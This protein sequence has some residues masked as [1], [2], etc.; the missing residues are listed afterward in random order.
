MKYHFR[1]HEEENG[2]WGQ[3]LEIDSCHSQGDTIPILKKMLEEALDLTLDEPAGSNMIFPMPDSK[4]NSIRDVITIPVDNKIAFAL[5]VRQNRISKRMTQKEAQEAMG[6][7]S[8]TSYTRLESKGNPTFSTIE[9][10]L[11]AFPDFPL[12]ECLPFSTTNY[13]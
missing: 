4:Y 9:K 1:I 6:L 12:Y 5:L 11:K 10:L 2:Y 8:R 7:P 3:C 13:L